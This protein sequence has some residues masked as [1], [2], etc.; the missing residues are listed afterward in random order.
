M[1]LHHVDWENDLNWPSMSWIFPDPPL[2]EMHTNATTL[3]YDVGLVADDWPSYVNYNSEKENQP[4]KWN[5]TIFDDELM[6]IQFY[7]NP[8]A[9]VHQRQMF[10]LWLFD[11]FAD[12]GGF[13]IFVGIFFYIPT[14]AV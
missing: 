12:I 13:L 9:V 5:S 10:K 2:R 8:I 6:K 4:R 14:A 7:L 11:Q 1:Q 3:R